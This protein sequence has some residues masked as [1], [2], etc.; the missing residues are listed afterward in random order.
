MLNAVGF[1]QIQKRQFTVQTWDPWTGLFPTSVN[2]KKIQNSAANVSSSIRLMRRSDQRSVDDR[3][4]FLNK[5]GLKYVQKKC[6]PVKNSLLS[7]RLC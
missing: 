5:N 4:V 1:S 6:Q 2:F 7:V 3:K